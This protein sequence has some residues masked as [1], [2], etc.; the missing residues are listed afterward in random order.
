MR[1]VFA[2][3]IVAVVALDLGAI[4]A[5]LRSRLAYNTVTGRPVVVNQVEALTYGTLPMANILAFTLLAGLT[6]IGR[7]PFLSGFLFAGIAALAAFTVLAY[8]RT[9]EIIQ[10]YVLWVLRSLPRSARK[11]TPAIRYPLNYSIAIVLVGLPQLAFAWLGGS[12]AS[13]TWHRAS[14][15]EPP[16]NGPLPTQYSL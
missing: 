6:G 3:A 5:C 7:R 15:I 16:C 4:R 12:L 10:P 14:P 1:I 9:E 11:L 13:L 2:M 8:F